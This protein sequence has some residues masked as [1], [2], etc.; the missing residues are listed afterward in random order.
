MVTYTEKPPDPG[1][2]EERPVGQ[3]GASE[4]GCG[5]KPVSGLCTLSG[6]GAEWNPERTEGPGRTERGYP[7][8][9]L[10]GKTGA[11]DSNPSGESGKSAGCHVSGFSDH[12]GTGRAVCIGLRKSKEKRVEKL[13]GTGDRVGDQ[14]VFIYVV[15]PS[16]EVVDE[17]NRCSIAETG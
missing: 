7:Q 5:F 1:L 13:S 14:S 3:S 6:G 2:Q 16:L 12:G 4:S 9:V 8:A 15:K 17:C 11:G 10:W